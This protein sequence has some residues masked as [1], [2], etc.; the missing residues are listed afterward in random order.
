MDELEELTNRTKRTINRWMQFGKL[1]ERLFPHREEGKQRY[2]TVAQAN[3]IAQLLA[4]ERGTLVDTTEDMHRFAVIMRTGYRFPD[5]IVKKIRS[6]IARNQSREQIND[7]LFPE[8]SYTTQDA[9]DKAIVGCCR[10][11]GFPVPPR[12]LTMNNLR[13]A[14]RLQAHGQCLEEIVNTL[15]RRTSYTGHIE[16][17]GD[18]VRAFELRDWELPHSDPTVPWKD[19]LTHRQQAEIR[20]LERQLKAI[21]RM[22]K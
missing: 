16:L 7:A 20:A 6:R 18:L 1:P 13:T 11:H 4:Q 12:Y 8:V 22:M 5:R 9:F 14:R 19:K 15:Y 3:E 21:E 10:Y 2:W 17:E